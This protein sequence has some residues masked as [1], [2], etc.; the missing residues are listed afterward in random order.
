MKKLPIVLAIA[1]LLTGAWTVHCQTAKETLL[2]PLKPDPPLTIDGNLDDWNAIPGTI[3]L[4]T[5]QHVTYSNEA[6]KNPADLSATVQLAWRQ[7]ALYVAVQVKDDVLRQ[8]QRGA[9]MWKGD[10]VELYLDIAPDTDTG[11]DTFGTQQF[12][13]GL[14]PGNFKRTGDMLSDIAPEAYVFQPAETSAEGIQ[15]GA[16]RTSNGYTI[17]ASIPWKIFHFS[18]Q[19]GLPLAVEVGVSDTDGIE[20]AQEKMMTLGTAKWDGVR[21]NLQRAI[22]AGADGSAPASITSLPLLETATIP[23]NGARE[24]PFNAPEIPQGY[25]AVLAV[26]GRLDFPSIGGYTPALSVELNGQPISSRRL[27][28]KQYSEEMGNGQMISMVAG[29]LFTVPYAPDFE[30][31]DKNTSYALRSGK[32]AY[33]EFRITDLLK[34]SGNNM[35]LKNIS[36]GGVDKTLAVGDVKL[37]YRMPSVSKELQGAPTGTL[38][39]IAPKTITPLNYAVTKNAGSSFALQFNENTFQVASQYSTPAGKWVTGPNEYFTVKRQ[40]EKQ[41]EWVIVRDTFT[42]LTDENLPLMHR[43]EVQMKPDKVWLGGLSPNSVLGTSS[44]P[45]NPTVFAVQ[46]KIGVGLLPL[47]DVFQVHITNY[48]TPDAI[49]L[50]DNTLV[51]KPKSTYTAEWAIVPVDS[52]DNFAF[53][54]ATRRLLDSNFSVDGSFAFMRANP[55][56]FGK[57]SDEQIINFAK[58]KDVR[59][60]CTDIGYPFYKERIPHGTAFQQIDLSGV[61]QTVE[62]RRKLLPG[63]KQIHYFHNFI[64]VADEAPEKFKDSQLLLQDG[65]QGDYGLSIYKLFVPTLEN[66]YGKAE[67]KSID[68]LL[69]YLKLDG[70]FW[71]EIDNSRYTY[72]YTPQEWDGV[73]A[74][75]DPQTMQIV[76]LKSSVTL[77]SQPWRLAQAKRIMKNGVLIGNGG[78][79]STRT[80]RDLK[81]IAFNETGSISHCVWSQLYTPIALGD[82]ITEKNQEDAY[83]TMLKALDY[84][85]VY[86]WYPDTLTPSYRT[87]THYM[88]PITPMELHKG[89]IIGKERIITNRSGI[90]GWNDNSKHEVHLF[91]HTGREVD[92]KDIKAPAS[93]KTSTQ[94]GQNWTEIRIAEGW[95]AAIIRK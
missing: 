5:K 28:N 60:L 25:E 90:F 55:D 56:T 88:F 91:D 86:Y 94:D 41:G 50:T 8:T 11:R 69:D 37:L 47:D 46:G 58:Y 21:S 36:Y 30:S 10:H 87:L 64:D 12:Q 68:I 32:S 62:R 49:G 20:A 14:S 6:W 67:A 34:Q 81:Y 76:R 3:N 84:G 15:V 23:S 61:K 72:T 31:V 54:N 83:G 39:K 92:L 78:L 2:I 18:P 89:Y 77:L 7:E 40:L 57:W 70:V 74:D 44:Q 17:E 22:V 93:V 66:S 35:I 29:N 26:W 75:I 80:M 82:H 27:L 85:C 1:S 19:V 71:D 16:Q 53:I 33:Y 65:T 9:N 43:N 4:D 63:V 48:S 79:P 24:I 73:S 42:N 13:I 51:L 52:S 95:S 59:Y 38:P 45:H